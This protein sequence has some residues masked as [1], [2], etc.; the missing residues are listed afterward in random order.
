MDVTAAQLENENLRK[1]RNRLMQWEG[2]TSPLAALSARQQEFFEI[3]DTV[4][5]R[6]K[7]VSLKVY[8]ISTSYNN[9]IGIISESHDDA[10]REQIMCN[11]D[12]GGRCRSVFINETTAIIIA[13]H[14]NHK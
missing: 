11:N 14:R 2:K 7:D 6:D 5:K 12:S 8:L 3:I 13:R 9:N 10:K 1:I 4:C